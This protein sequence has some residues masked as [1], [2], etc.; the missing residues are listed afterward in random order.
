M[1]KINEKSLWKLNR[2]IGF[3][4]GC[5]MWE[6]H[7]DWCNCRLAEGGHGCTA[8]EPWF[9]R[10]IDYVLEVKPRLSRSLCAIYKNRVILFQGWSCTADIG[11]GWL[12]WPNG[13]LKQIWLK[14]RYYFIMA[15]T[16]CIQGVRGIS[17]ILL[18]VAGDCRKDQ[19]MYI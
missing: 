12:W 13:T 10:V 16:V 11:Y 2:N 4:G 18:T 6:S 9:H 3:P 19:K 7:C 8:R 5:T 17:A 15:H 1:I 14:F